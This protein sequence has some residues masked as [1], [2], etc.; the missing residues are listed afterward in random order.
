[1]S[2]ASQ[3]GL[4]S[5]NTP[6]LGVFTKLQP[7]SQAIPRISLTAGHPLLSLHL[8]SPSL[9]I[10]TS[11][12]ALSSAL[13]TP[14]IPRALWPNFRPHPLPPYPPQEPLDQRPPTQHCH[15]CLPKPCFTPSTCCGSPGPVQSSLN[16]LGCIFK[17]L[18]PSTQASDRK[19]THQTPS[20]PD[21]P[22]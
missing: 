12:S 3:L 13:L 4:A 20:P 14:I 6:S 22:V 1:M 18:Q 7:N 2:H 17:V 16:L 11:P 19:P 10:I 21:H 8:G 5:P 15:H 9:C